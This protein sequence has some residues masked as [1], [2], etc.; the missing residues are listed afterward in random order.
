MLFTL[1]E[2]IDHCTRFTNICSFVF[3]NRWIRFVHFTFI[4]IALMSFTHFQL[5]SKESRI[6]AIKRYLPY[7]LLFAITLQFLAGSVHFIFTVPIQFF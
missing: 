2:F 7:F 3:A 1:T 5:K 6:V 4:G